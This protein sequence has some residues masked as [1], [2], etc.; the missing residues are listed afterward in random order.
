MKRIFKTSF[1]LGAGFGRRL[2]PYTDS[3]PKPLLP[4]WGKPIICHIIDRLIDYGFERFIVNT[5][6]CHELYERYFPERS[7]RGKEIVLRYE[8]RLLNTGGAL[9]NIEDLLSEDEIILCHNGDIITTMPY[10]RLM[11]FHLKERPFITF[12]LRTQGPEMHVYTDEKCNVL[13]IKK[14]V[15]GC[16]AYQF[17]GVYALDTESLSYLESGNPISLLDAVEIL[18]R[19]GKEKV[20]GVVIDEGVWYDI[21]SVSVYE[22]LKSMEKSEALGFGN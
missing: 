14:N 6:H 1:I 15:D 9:K 4:L 18:S 22:K 19:I 5:H 21:G 3:T 13:S 11:D 16:R 2:R 17:T 20:K 10:E 8:P 7:W 12:S